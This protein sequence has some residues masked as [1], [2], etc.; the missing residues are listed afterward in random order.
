MSCSRC[1]VFFT[2]YNSITIKFG[3]NQLEDFVV[4][5]LT[6]KFTFNF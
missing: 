4:Y 5:N 6:M 3:F 2:V 1:F